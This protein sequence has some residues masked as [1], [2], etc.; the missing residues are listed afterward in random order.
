MRHCWTIHLS[1]CSRVSEN[2]RGKTL[3]GSQDIHTQRLLLLEVST[4][5]PG[6]SHTNSLP[7]SARRL[8]SSFLP[9]MANRALVVEGCVCKS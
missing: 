5:S 6:V 4:S 3:D 1:L 2:K 7:V 8:G 9:Y